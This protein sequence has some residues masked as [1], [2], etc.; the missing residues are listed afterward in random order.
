MRGHLEPLSAVLRIGGAYGEPFTWSGMLRYLGPSEVEFV[1][2][3]RKAELG[4]R[5][6]IPKVLRAA[7]IRYAWFKRISRGAT[8]RCTVFDDRP[9]ETVMETAS[10]TDVK[11]EF[12]ATVRPKK[13]LR[14]SI[15]AALIHSN[16][17]MMAGL[18][19]EKAQ[20]DA[21][22]KASVA[23]TKSMRAGV[24]QAVDDILANTGA[25]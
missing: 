19:A 23:L 15:K 2:I 21:D 1:G 20:A 18:K 3:A 24:D 10:V 13:N 12:K 11:S 16:D 6:E 14:A 4:E 5:R 8:R 9:K 22:Y 17:L 7:G 25:E